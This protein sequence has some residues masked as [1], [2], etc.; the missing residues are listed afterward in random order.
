MALA[1]GLA[2]GLQGR[3]EECE[4]YER[5]GAGGVLV[6]RCLK[7]ARLSPASFSLPKETY[8]KAYLD[9]HVFEEK[10]VKRLGV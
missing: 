7:I 9:G 8:K 1:Q 4:Q 3:A 6:I 2:K 10:T 5:G